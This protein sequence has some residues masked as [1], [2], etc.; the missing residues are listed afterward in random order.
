MLLP[1]QSLTFI[2]VFAAMEM[3]LCPPHPPPPHT[4]FGGVLNLGGC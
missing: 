1:H 3:G 2:R 4:K